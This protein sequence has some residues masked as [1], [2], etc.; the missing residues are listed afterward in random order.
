MAGKWIALAISR[1]K[2]LDERAKAPA[3]Q[4]P[5]NLPLRGFRRQGPGMFGRKRNK[6]EHRYYLLPGMGRANKRKR[7][8]FFRVALAVGFL[9]SLIVAYLIY[10]TNRL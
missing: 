6:E 5:A 4:R 9:V 3:N 2:R 7:T 8:T 1:P 10:Q